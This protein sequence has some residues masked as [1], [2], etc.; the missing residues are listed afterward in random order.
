MYDSYSPE[1]CMY[2]STQFDADPCVCTSTNVVEKYLYAPCQVPPEL[3]PVPKY[4]ISVV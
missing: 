2:N 3:T 4:V 1:P